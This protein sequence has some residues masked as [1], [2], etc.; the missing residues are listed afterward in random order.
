MARFQTTLD[1]C[2][3][4]T[5]PL[6]G[7][8]HRV[9]TCPQAESTVYFRLKTWMKVM[10]KATPNFWPL[11]LPAR[12]LSL[13]VNALSRHLNHVA[14]SGLETA[15]ELWISLTSSLQTQ[16]LKYSGKY[17]AIL[18]EEVWLR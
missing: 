1:M 18:L 15:T 11:W 4:I 13:P 6:T 8:L 3:K 17:G 14:V 9:Y 2:R 12:L 7:P 10:K 16:W 5:C